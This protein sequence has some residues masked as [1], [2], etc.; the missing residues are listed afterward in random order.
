MCVF[1]Y[2][3]AIGTTTATGAKPADEAHA[4][5]VDVTPVSLGGVKASTE[6]AE[7]ISKAMK[8]YLERSQAH[9]KQLYSTSFSSFGFK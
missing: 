9:S 8:A 6:K 2:L 3:R 5:R 1:Q 7:K 4:K